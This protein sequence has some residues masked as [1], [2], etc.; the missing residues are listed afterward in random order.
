MDINKEKQIIILTI[1]APQT[2]DPRKFGAYSDRSMD[3]NHS[4]TR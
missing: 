2:P 3:F 4:I 1:N